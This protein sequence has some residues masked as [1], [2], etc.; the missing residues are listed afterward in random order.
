MSNNLFQK[1]FLPVLGCFLGCVLVC[2]LLLCFL[3]LVGFL[4]VLFGGGGVFCIVYDFPVYKFYFR[5][6][7]RF[8]ILF[9]SQYLDQM[10]LNTFGKLV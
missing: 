4:C 6:L 3:L 10:L 2:L 7:E 8:Y 9:L 1:C 5:S